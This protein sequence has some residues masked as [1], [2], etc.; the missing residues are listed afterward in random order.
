VKFWINNQKALR[1]QNEIYVR[2]IV[3]TARRFAV[4]GLQSQA[5]VTKE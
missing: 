1:L 5:F 3:T 4:S 2:E